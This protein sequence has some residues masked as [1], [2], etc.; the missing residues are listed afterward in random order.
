MSVSDEI[1]YVSYTH[2]YFKNKPVLLKAPVSDRYSHVTPVLCV[3]RLYVYCDSGCVRSLL[4]VEASARQNTFYST[5]AKSTEGKRSA[6]IVTLVSLVDGPTA[7]DETE[8][9]T[10][11][12]QTG[13]ETSTPR[14]LRPFA[15][16]RLFI[17]SQSQR[18]CL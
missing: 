5:L 2:F 10:S 4:S 15:F 14:V 8:T 7:G 17:S 16:C 11:Y 9:R 13:C 3:C 1:V 6:A 12:W 18:C